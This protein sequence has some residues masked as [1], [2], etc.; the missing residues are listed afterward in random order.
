MAKISRQT[1]EIIQIVVFLLVVALLLI[2]YVIYPL[3]RTKAVF[4]RPNIDDDAYSNDS[5]LVNDPA[6][7]VDA[8]LTPD[9]FRVESEG[10]VNIA[11]VYVAGLVD[12]AGQPPRGTVLLAHREG[13]TRDSMVWLAKQLVDSGWNV[14]AYDQRASGLSTGK[15]RG[16]G[17]YEAHH[18]EDIIAYADVRDLMTEPI[19]AVGFGSTADGVL[20]ASREDKRLDIAVAVEPYL[21]STRM[22]NMVR[23]HYD[24]YWF[25]FFR[26]MMWWCYGMRSGYDGPYRGIESL[27]PVT[28]TTL[29]YVSP[30]VAKDKAV[31][32]LVNM[33]DPNLLHAEAMIPTDEELLQAINRFGK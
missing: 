6:A 10:E 25:P 9:T 28:D 22:L 5:L 7:F 19:V 17:V 11:C 23:K 12:S 31:A 14:L 26:T 21:T 1:K 29:L 18:L 30:D 13:Q 33:S 15:Y 24:M 20:I 32:E 16:E 2:F 8:G 3:N 4:A 27:R